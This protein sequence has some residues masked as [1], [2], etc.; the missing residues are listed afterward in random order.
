MT[1][2]HE[3][4]LSKV[5]IANRE[6]YQAN[7]E[8]IKARKREQYRQKVAS[9]PER[10]SPA[11]KAFNIKRH[12]SSDTYEPAPAISDEKRRQCK[13]RRDIENYLLDRELGLHDL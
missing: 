9:Q 5:Q 3:R 2:P 13:T 8:R 11:N 6:Y 10:P 7:A 12:P 4:P 1:S